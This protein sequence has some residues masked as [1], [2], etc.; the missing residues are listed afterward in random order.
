MRGNIAIS[1]YQGNVT[2]VDLGQLGELPAGQVLR[3][4]LFANI[5]SPAF[6]LQTYSPPFVDFWGYVDIFIIRREW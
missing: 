2:G 1:L 6:I 5:G 4:S 3:F